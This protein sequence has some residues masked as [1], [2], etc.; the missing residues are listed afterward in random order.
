MQ[1]VLYVSH[2]SRV[3]EATAEAMAC[4]RA[5][6]EEVAV[7]LQKICFLELADPS[8]EQAIETLI[9]QGASSIVIVPVLLL[10][11]G[12]YYKDIPNK[13]AL[14]QEK[15]PFVTFTYGQP[16]GV[17]DRFIDVLAERAAA[18]DVPIGSETKV[19]LVGRGSRN[20]QTKKDIAMIGQKL[21]RLLK[22]EH[23]DV[24]F[25]AVCDPSFEEKLQSSVE[26]DYNHL[27]IVPYLWFTGVLMCSI[28]RKIKELK[29][30]NM[31]IVLC[32]QL[33][34]HAIMKQALKERVHEAF[35]V[36]EALT[37]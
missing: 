2:G 20:P 30:P 31:K 11:A 4:I 19:L 16:L 32:H 28:V 5:V 26:E 21:Q 6:K 1:S 12:H 29:Q 17:Q 15:Y 37:I 14:E 24:C 10:A 22:T 8:V 7:P 23:V 33:G 35:E 18:T 9:N 34:D 36:A 3:P 13:I 27:L 25:L